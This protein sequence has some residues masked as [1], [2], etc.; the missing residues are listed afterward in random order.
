MQ[1]IFLGL[2]TKTL[3]NSIITNYSIMEFYAKQLINSYG[4]IA[5]WICDNLIL[6]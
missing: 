6:E 5:N 4:V 2:R 3:Q 1:F